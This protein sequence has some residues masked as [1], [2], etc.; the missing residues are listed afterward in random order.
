MSSTILLF[1][2]DIFI[3]EGIKEVCK[4]LQKDLTSYTYSKHFRE[5]LENQKRENRSH[6]YLE[7][8]VR[9]CVNSLKE[10][11]R[12]V[13]EVELT[14]EKSYSWKVTKYCCRIPYDDKQD[15]VVAI[16]PVY[17]NDT[18][19]ENKIVTA[20]MN[21]HDDSHYTLDESKYCSRPHWDAINKYS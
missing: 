3:P 7:D 19:V 12:Q 10:R 2:K 14:E 8:V 13:F 6:L 15:L 20:W 16:R 18:V 21:Q 11:P 1:H 17:F 9:E 4:Q 5:H